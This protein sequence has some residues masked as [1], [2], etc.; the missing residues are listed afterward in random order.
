MDMTGPTNP[1]VA[2][3]LC[4]IL[5]PRRAS[6]RHTR[7]H[8]VTKCVQSLLA[9]SY[10]PLEVIVVDQSPDNEL[11]A[12][13]Q[14]LSEAD[15]RLRYIHTDIV[16]LTRSQNRAIRSS[17]AELF[18]F[19]DDDCIVPPDWIARIVETFR[20]HPD[21]GLVFG[22]VH[23]PTE[24]DWT[25]SYV[26][27]LHFRHEE[28]LRPSFLPRTHSLMGAN[29]AARRTTFARIGLL[30]ESFGP[31]PYNGEVELTLRALR[32]CP[33]IN[34]YLTPA[35]QIVHEYGGRSHGEPARRLLHTYHMGKSAMLTKHALRG[36]LGAACGLVLLAFEP[37]VQAIVNLGRIGKPRRLG[38][39][40]PYVQ[41]VV[42]T[43]RAVRGS[44]DMPL[45]H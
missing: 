36:D 16:G 43:V 37:F 25:T 41:G 21:A 31:H 20:R 2:A 38:M 34:V 7:L 17:D 33:S 27:E 14:P 18:A 10:K 6:A 45:L 12:A 11:A 8:E 4:T 26:P 39:V 1:K 24:H 35:F 42:R 3:I 22:D 40:V 28:Q 23:A 29:M 15:S 5:G 32:A 30:E 13:L 9:N 19:T 44:T